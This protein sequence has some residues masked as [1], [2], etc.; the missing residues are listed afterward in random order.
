MT[1]RR[2]IPHSAPSLGEAEAEA[3]RRA[4]LSG[5]VAQ[6]PEVA[7]FEEAC[8]AFTGY[9][10]AI[11]VS[12][13]TAALHLALVALGAS[14]HDAVITPSYACDAL[15]TAVGLAGLTPTLYDV[16]P[17]GLMTVPEVETD[18]PTIVAHLFGK[19]A[20][21]PRGKHVIED[22]AQSFGGP[23]GPMAPIAITS[24]YATKVMTTGEGGMVFT[25]DAGLAEHVRDR[26][27]YDKREGLRQRYNYK[28]TD[29][30]AAIGRVQLGRLKSFVERRRAIAARYQDALAP[31]PLT[32][33]E[34]DPDHI[35][36][37]YVVYLDARKALETHLQ[38]QGIDA[39]RPVFRP[40]HHVLGGTFPG[41]DRM[42]R[43]A[44]SLPVH[45]NLDDADIQAVIHSTYEFFG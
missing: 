33:P 30:Q 41:A 25:G 9:P 43:V 23:A 15:V 45:P 26:R 31:L 27:D 18:A 35:F 12:S 5:K 36:F 29:I 6:G 40:A 8:A 11:A 7:A 39:K 14:Q 21:V 13:G 2:I 10:H 42:H 1:E 32:L 34:P 20:A 38:A 3:A 37:R 44:L 24:F 16:G 17:E 22:L 28:M 19:R 4:V